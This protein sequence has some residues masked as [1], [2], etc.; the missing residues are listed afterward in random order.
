VDIQVEAT[1]ESENQTSVGMDCRHRNRM[2]HPRST[3]LAVGVASEQGATTD[4]NRLPSPDT[5]EGDARTRS[6]IANRDPELR[7][8]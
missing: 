6:Q 8:P 3:R 5:G 2:P 1:L 4:R 7:V